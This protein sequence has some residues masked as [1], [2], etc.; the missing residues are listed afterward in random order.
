MVSKAQELVLLDI[1]IFWNPCSGAKDVHLPASG[2]QIE[3]AFFLCLY[4]NIL[5]TS[6]KSKWIYKNLIIAVFDHRWINLSLDSK[7]HF[8]LQYKTIKLINSM[9]MQLLFKL[10]TQNSY[11][12]KCHI[13]KINR[14]KWGKF[15]V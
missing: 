7:K 10:V 1:S 12:S 2:T 3:Y 9:K 11:V 13:K 6:D 14:I 15:L 8:R 4:C 5:N